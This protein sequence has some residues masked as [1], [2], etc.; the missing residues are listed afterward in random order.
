[1]RAEGG[2]GLGH[3]AT[4]ATAAAGDDRYP[5]GEIEE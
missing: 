1:V 5:T 4:D 3:R 2:K